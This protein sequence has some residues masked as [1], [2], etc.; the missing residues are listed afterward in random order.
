MATE[1]GI[2][3]RYECLLDP[4][5]HYVVWDNATD[6]PGMMGD[7]ILAFSTRREAL[8]AIDLLNQESRSSPSVIR[9]AGH[10]Q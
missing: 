10:R 7:E 2:T 4:L 1:T 8:A 5:D 9:V 3:D 6:L